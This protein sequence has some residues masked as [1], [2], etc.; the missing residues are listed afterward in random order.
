MHSNVSAYKLQC[1][2]AEGGPSAPQLRDR[3]VT[4]SWS[5]FSI[6]SLPMS[7]TASIAELVMIG[8][9]NT[10]N[11]CL[12]IPLVAQREPRSPTVSVRVGSGLKMYRARLHRSSHVLAQGGMSICC[13]LA[14]SRVRY[15]W[16][17]H[18]G[19]ERSPIR[20]ALSGYEA[21]AVQSSVLS[22]AMC[23]KI[24]VR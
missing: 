19:I 2:P 15:A 5:S 12:R 4:D 23:Y 8:M 21:G 16:C 11:R 14:P 6:R 1:T 9:T 24:D 20:L 22:T 7:R 13:R 18:V 3:M 10:A 17:S